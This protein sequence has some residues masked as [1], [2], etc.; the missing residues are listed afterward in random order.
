MLTPLAQASDPARFGGKA[1]ELARG[2]ELGL[3]VPDGFA[4]DVEAAATLVSG[5]GESLARLANPAIHT[6][7]WAVRSSAVGEDGTQA[8]FAGIHVTR[9]HVR[10]D[11]L[12]DAVA[13]VVASAHT[14]AALAYRRRLG[15]EEAPRMAVVVQQMVEVEVAGVL[16]T[17]DPLTGAHVRVVEASWGLGE[18]VVAGLVTPDSFRMTPGGELVDQ[19]G[20]YKD[21]AVVW[22]DDG[23]T[24]EVELEP[25]RREA[26]C[27]DHARL[28]A[29][30]RLAARIE[31]AIEGG[32]D[33]E[34]AFDV[35]GEGPFLLQR[36]PITAVRTGPGTV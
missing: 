14:E 35:R 17:R 9:L 24:R 4:L 8:S 6:R 19:R 7:R 13:E 10:G 22:D 28:R 29:L 1:V 12:D 34:W 18:V 11:R 23:G 26:L 20:G 3:P 27:L 25:E 36:R 2:L 16:F 31:Q 15:I 33:I 21:I 5:S 32:H 30:D